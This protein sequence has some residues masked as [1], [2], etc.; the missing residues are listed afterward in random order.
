M[1]HGPFEAVKAAMV[2]SVP[3]MSTYNTL[4]GSLQRDG[5]ARRSVLSS[6]LEEYGEKMS[7]EVEHAIMSACGTA[8]DG[9][10]FVDMTLQLGI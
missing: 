3:C 4:M 9:G 6:L 2:S 8:Y 5:S 10:C 1:A 7:K